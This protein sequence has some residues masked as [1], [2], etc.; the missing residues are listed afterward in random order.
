M[1]VLFFIS[2]L[3]VALSSCAKH[4]EKKAYKEI[5][6]SYKADVFTV[7]DNGDYHVEANTLGINEVGVGLSSDGEEMEYGCEFSLVENDRPEYDYKLSFD[8]LRL[9]ILNVATGQFTE[10]ESPSKAQLNS[11]RSFYLKRLEGDK[12]SLVIKSNSGDIEIHT[13]TK[14]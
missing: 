1:R 7:Y 3:A 12:I 9:F 14:Q 6:G 2:V 13:F 8:R 10:Q 4:K 11:G 5:W